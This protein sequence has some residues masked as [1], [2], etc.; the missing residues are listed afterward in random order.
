MT[1]YERDPLVKCA[2]QRPVCGHTRREHGNGKCFGVTFAVGVAGDCH[3]KG[4]MEPPD[5][6]RFAREGERVDE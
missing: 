2:R 1:G 6:A 3:C 4:M 5:P